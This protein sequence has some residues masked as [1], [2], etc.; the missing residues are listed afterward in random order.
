VTASRKG[1]SGP[2]SFFQEQFELALGGLF[3]SSLAA[4]GSA[5]SIR[6]NLH[7]LRGRVKPLC[8]ANKKNA[9]GKATRA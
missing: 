7:L 4:F 1:S 3:V 2:T 5:A 9:G 8:M 6:L